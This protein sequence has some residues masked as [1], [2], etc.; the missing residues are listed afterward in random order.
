MLKIAIIIGSTRPQRVGESVA[1][2]VHEHAQKRSDATFELVDIR[3]YNLP[4][5]DEPIPPSQGKYSKDH[6]KKWAAKIAEFDAYIFVTPEYNYFP[7]AALVNSVQSLMQEWFYK[8]AGV[9]SYG[10]ISGGLRAAQAF[11]QLLG[12]VNVH[13][14]PQVVP[15]P[16]VTQFIGEDGVFRPN[17]PMTDGLNGMLDELHKWTTA[18]RTLRP[19]RVE[20]AP[21]ETELV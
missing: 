21:R 14:L 6:T 13:S 9:V 2:W 1:T 4:L 19:A 15:A 7:P 11:R 10:G 20:A 18:L 17:E 16:M 8:P 3:D 5:L 12:N